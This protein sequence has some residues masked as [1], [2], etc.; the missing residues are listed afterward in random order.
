MPHRVTL[1]PSGESYLVEE[2]ENLLAAAKR[3]NLPLPHACQSGSCGSCKATLVDGLS[4]HSSDELPGLSTTERQAGNILLCMSTAQSDLT[5]SMPH[6]QGA[7]A[8]PA[9][10]M[11]ARIEHIDIYG[12]NA[13]VH[14]TLPRNKPFHFHAGQYIDILLPQQQR[15]SYS[16]ASSPAEHGHLQLHIRHH[17]GGVFSTPLFNG[18][19]AVKSV[20]RIHGPLGSFGLIQSDQPILMLATGTG[21]APIKSMLAELAE[22]NSLRSIHVFWGARNET[23]L[24]QMDAII[25]LVSAL[26]HAQ[27]TPVLSQAS[28]SWQ[29]ARGHV[30]D[31]AFKAYPDLRQHHVYACGSLAM[32][33]DA[34]T[35]FSTQAQLAAHAF[36]AD[37]F[38]PA[39]TTP[40]I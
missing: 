23:E 21:I 1:L 19:T 18:T 15:R 10:M 29:G 27:F 8:A 6:Y 34:Q 12:A 37:G 16:I 11:A 17:A 31:C 33:Q 5:L 25:A 9:Q 24:Y 30:Q 4:S 22:Q 3:H 39:T 20:L 40:S 35:L 26:A 14:L 36:F 32:I 13:V 7:H 38:T 2:G 28:A